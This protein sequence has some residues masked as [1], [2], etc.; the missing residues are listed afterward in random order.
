M[1]VRQDEPGLAVRRLQLQRQF[2]HGARL[3]DQLLDLGPVRAHDIGAPVD[4]HLRRVDG[5]Q[6]QRAR[7][8][9]LAPGEVGAGEGVLPADV[10][11]VVD[12]EGKG[13]HVPALRQ[14]AK[15]RVGRR[16]GAAAL[17][18]EQLDHDR[19]GGF[20][21]AGVQRRGV[22][23]EQGKRGGDPGA[24]HAVHHAPPP[25]RPP[26]HNAVKAPASR[27]TRGIRTPSACSA[28]RNAEFRHGG[29]NPARRRCRSG[30]S[31]ARYRCGR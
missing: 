31:R 29:S 8:A 17:R 12:M 10:V 4:H 22:R 3:S 9:A 13:D 15:E 6:A 19:R 18:G 7:I 30:R 25:G 11:P 16:A 24:V 26:N 14:L 20:G 28:A 5:A 1:R 27:R 2:R 23:S 21:R